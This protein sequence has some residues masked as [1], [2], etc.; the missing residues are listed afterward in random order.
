MNVC[1]Q[2]QHIQNTEAAG[3][4]NHQPKFWFNA[5]QFPWHILKTFVVESNVCADRV[6]A[7]HTSPQDILAMMQGIKSRKKCQAIIDF[8]II[9]NMEMIIQP[10]RM[11]TYPLEIIGNYSTSKRIKVTQLF[12]N[13][14]CTYPNKY[15]ITISMQSAPKSICRDMRLSSQKVE[16]LFQSHYCWRLQHN[17]LT[18]TI[19]QRHSLNCSFR[20]ITMNI[21]LTHRNI[22]CKLYNCC[23]AMSLSIRASWEENTVLN[24]LSLLLSGNFFRQCNQKITT[25]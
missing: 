13:T 11:C 17:K 1:L 22:Y 10:L 21:L 3:K 24:C 6:H 9:V 2:S 8:S 20:W 4:K 16:Y 7:P 19:Y 23:K 15:V 25:K 18:D 14:L 12:T 5:S